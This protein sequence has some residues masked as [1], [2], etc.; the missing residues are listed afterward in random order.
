MEGFLLALILLVLASIDFT[1]GRIAK[2]LQS[3]QSMQEREHR[4]MQPP[5]ED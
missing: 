4:H 1:L 5:P 2:T 3:M